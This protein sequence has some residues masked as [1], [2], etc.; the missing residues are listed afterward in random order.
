MGKE[1]SALVV[2]PSEGR[3]GV[4]L[5]QSSTCQEECFFTDVCC[6]V[7]GSDPT[8]CKVKYVLLDGV[9]KRHQSL[10]ML[11]KSRPGSSRGPAPSALRWAVCGNEQ[12]VSST[13]NPWGNQARPSRLSLCSCNAV[14]DCTAHSIHLRD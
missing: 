13:S 2:Q 5:T 12:A 1:L 4:S 3:R 6:R 8:A 10:Q 11:G 14:A 9:P 7:L